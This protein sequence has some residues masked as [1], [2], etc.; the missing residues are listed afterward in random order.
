MFLVC[1][2]QRGKRDTAAANGVLKQKRSRVQTA[3]TFVKW[4]L[5]NSA[6]SAAED[7]ISKIH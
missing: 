4:T 3:N 1:R 2:W 6:R 5:Q 7:G